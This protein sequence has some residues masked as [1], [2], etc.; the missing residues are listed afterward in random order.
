[1]FLKTFNLIVLSVFKLDI[2]N[3]RKGFIFKLNHEKRGT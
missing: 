2:F 1:M 3:Q